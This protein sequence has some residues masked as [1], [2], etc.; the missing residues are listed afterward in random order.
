LAGGVPLAGA[1]GALAASP[2]VVDGFVDGISEPVGAPGS[3]GTL[4]GEFAG[5]G[6]VC[7]CSRI[8]PD[9]AAALCEPT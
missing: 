7:S 2:G 8:V 9:E 3:T 1:A 6:C 4:V 5:A